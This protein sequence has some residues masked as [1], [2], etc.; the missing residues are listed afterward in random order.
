MALADDYT[1][2]TKQFVTLP[3]YSLFPNPHS[4]L[5]DIHDCNGKASKDLRELFKLLQFESFA[6][7]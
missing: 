4:L 1:K 2:E 5:R 3:M 6:V 7:S